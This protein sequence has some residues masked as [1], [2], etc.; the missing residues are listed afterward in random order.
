MDNIRI[1][2]DIVHDT[3]KLLSDFYQDDETSFVFTADHGMS[4]IGNHGDGRQCLVNFGRLSWTNVPSCVDPDSTRTPLIAWG[5][6]VRGPL[7]DAS[8]SSHDEYSK[9]WGLQHLYRRDVEQADIASLMATL[10]GIDW[11]V[12]SVGVLPDVDPMRPGYLDAGDSDEKIAKAAL[13]NAKVILEQ[14]RVK[15]GLSYWSPFLPTMF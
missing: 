2:D 14:Y 3:E 15:H 10:I 12:N 8:P 5:R 7:P 1:V 11:P 6:G 9:P 4:V 13:V